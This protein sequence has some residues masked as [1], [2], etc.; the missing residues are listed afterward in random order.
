MGYASYTVLI[1]VLCPRDE[2]RM[3]MQLL[4]GYVG[5]LSGALFSPIAV[6]EA[7]FGGCP[8]DDDSPSPGP[9]PLPRYL[10]Q[11]ESQTGL[12]SMSLHICPTLSL[13]VLAY[14]VGKALMDNVLSDYLWARAVIL[15]SAT[16]AT[17][18]LGLTIP[19]AFLSDWII[20]NKD[21]SNV[22]SI[23]GACSVLV[24]FIFVNCGEGGGD[25]GFDIESDE[26]GVA[27]EESDVEITRTDAQLC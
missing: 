6:K 26:E 4:L 2:S 5:L 3:S 11:D 13:I 18:G 14:V 25:D 22:G 23:L 19:L 27:T 7:F 12:L 10:L 16:V 8:A 24:G 9:S 21:V 17:V 20:G 15:T 1:R